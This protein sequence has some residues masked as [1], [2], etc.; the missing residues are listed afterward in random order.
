MS[1]VKSV[2][3]TCEEATMSRPKAYDP[4][5][6]LEAAMRAFW[7]QGYVSTSLA[8]LTKAMGINKFTLYSGFGDKRAV[9]LASLDHYSV[10]V[11]EELLSILEQK[12]GHLNAIKAYFEKLLQG[13]TTPQQCTGCL[14]TL[15]A[16]ELAPDDAE[17]RRKVQRHFR[18]IKSAFE[19]TLGRAITA[20][21]LS[22][23][24]NVEVL[25]THLMMCT[26]SIAVLSRAKPKASEFEGFVDWLLSALNC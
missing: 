6:A 4:N 2:E 10:T 25:S 3:L 17:V 20:G 9:F 26:Q 15:S 18:R 11:V 5:V 22:R 12:E 8:D 13:A 24:V 14:M 21:E 1:G 16:S 23:S 19:V 7:Q